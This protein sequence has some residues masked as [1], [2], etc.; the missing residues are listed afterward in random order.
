M[1]TMKPATL[2]MPLLLA[3]AAGAPGSAHAWPWESAAEKQ[4]R[5][6]ANAAKEAQTELGMRML[7]KQCVD[8]YPAE[9]IQPHPADAFRDQPPQPAKT[10]LRP[11]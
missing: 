7:M 6:F 11:R 8:K 5:C 4:Q 9:A 1:S 2:V 10:P 3:L